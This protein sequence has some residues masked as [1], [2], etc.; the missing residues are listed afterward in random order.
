MSKAIK[1]GAALAISA[2]A[3]LTIA[4][5][6]S[7][8]GDSDNGRQSYTLEQVESGAL[9]N[10]I[11]FNSI[12]NSTI[13]NEK[14]FVSARENDGSTDVNKTWQTGE[15]TVE[16]G[17][18]YIIRLYAHNNNP[19]GTNTVAKDT[20]VRFNIP[21]TSES[22]LTVNG[23]I[24]SSNATPKQ[25]WDS[26][27]FKGPDGRSFY[28]DY[29]EGSATFWNNKIGLG[30]LKVSDNV[31]T[32]NGIKIGYES[33][34]GNIPGCYEY[35]SYTT[36]VVK[37]VFTDNNFVVDKRVKLH[38][39]DADWSESVEA[40]TGDLVDFV[41]KYQNTTENAVSSVALRDILPNNME[42]AS[43]IVLK[44]GT[45]PNGLVLKGN[46]TTGWVDIGGYGVDAKAYIYLTAKVVDKDMICGKN[47]LRNWGQIGVGSVTRQDSADVVVQKT[48][49]EPEPEPKKDCTTNPELPECK[50]P[51]PEPEKNC[52]T[53]PEMA[54]CKKEEPK[55]DDTP[56]E[57]PS[58][59]ATEIVAG[60]LGVGSTVTA[61]GYY[62]ASRKTL[63]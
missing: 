62:L 23:Y 1:I 57:M 17:K 27:I 45:N 46:A 42:L 24:S 20:T 28:L 3:G 8:W 10:K 30:G 7:A 55:K 26:I 15:L 49:D 63:R 51:E 36:I 4:E 29:V 11:V 43:D 32:T 53:N 6:V 39:S 12:S 41:I 35:A 40:K 18:E 13:G 37:P 34:D 52:T 31:I 60:A 14:Y 22:T 19:Q 59:G 2:V 48:C 47:I 38:G 21:T 54:E 50:K 56:K 61:A 9:K 44:N 58:T 33:L 16:E 5:G 25:Y